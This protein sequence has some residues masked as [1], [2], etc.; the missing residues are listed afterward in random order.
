MKP[1]QSVVQVARYDDN[2]H[3]FI[4][5][6]GLYVRDVTL[7]L[8]IDEEICIGLLNDVHLNYCNQQDFLEANPVTMSTYQNRQFCAGAACLPKLHNCMAA[9]EGADAVV[10]NG[11]TMDYL[12][13]GTVELMQK[14]V[15][16]KYPEVIAT[17]GGHER[18]RRMQGTVPEQDT[19]EDRMQHLQGFWA[20]DIYYTSKCIKNQVLVI[21]LCNDMARFTAEQH[22]KL[23]ADLESARQ[24]GW[25][26]LLFMH[27]P[28]ATGNPAHANIALA[29]VMLLGDRGGFPLDYCFGA[30]QTLPGNPACDADTLATYNTILN[31]AD[32]IK[33]VFVG[34]RHSDM[35]LEI[36]ARTPDGAAAVIPQFVHNATA[37]HN[38]HLMRIFIK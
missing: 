1:L 2:D 13:H 18:E 7:H 29:D 35:H 8:G 20:H 15:F 21:G 33:G 27:E 10:L 9:L 19:Y 37:Y 5:Q 16:Q 6:S 31:S 17:V 28:I 12:S 32:V 30:D 26:V 24:K 11:D 3:I 23:Q 14:E 38:G 25:R 22:Q 4:E 36:L 34:H